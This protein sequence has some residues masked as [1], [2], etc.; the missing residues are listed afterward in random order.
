MLSTTGTGHAGGAGSEGAPTIP[1][2]CTVASYGL[3]GPHASR[4]F[5]EAGR[6]WQVQVEHATRPSVTFGILKTWLEYKNSLRR[7]A[8]KEETATLDGLEKEDGL[9]LILTGA[10]DEHGCASFRAEPRLASSRRHLVIMR[11]FCQVRL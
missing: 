3:P 2:R 4:Y 10:E 8:G 1:V 7:A 11:F 5:P 9:R 6:V